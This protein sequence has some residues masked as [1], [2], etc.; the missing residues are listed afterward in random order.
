VIE[1]YAR[2]AITGILSRGYN[3][4]LALRDKSASV[5]GKPAQ[6]ILWFWFPRLTGGVA[7]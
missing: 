7:P 5:R 6:D 1:A 4:V 3:P 2:P